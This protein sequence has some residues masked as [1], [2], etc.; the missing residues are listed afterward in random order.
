MES[1]EPSAKAPEIPPEEGFRG[2]LCV[3]GSSLA[4][5]STFG[6]LNAI[7]VFQ[8]TYQSTTLSD[9]T[10]S[11][12]S[13]IFA[14][15]LSLMWAPGPFYGRIIDTYG[16]APVLYP[17]ALLCVFSLCMTSLADRYYQIFLAQGL[18]FGL[19]AG[20]VF[21][22][23][24]VCAGQWFVRRRG[25]AL[26][27]A[28]AGSSLGGVV[29]P[30]FIDRVILKVGFYGAIRYTA[31]LV[32][33]PL[34]A[35]LFMIRARLPRK[36]WNSEVPWFD[37]SLFREKQFALYVFGA[38]MVMWGL[39]GPYDFITSMAE[40]AGFSPTLSLYLISLLSATSV[41]GRILPAYLGDTLG[42]FNV[43]STFAFL[44]G[45]SILTLWLPFDYHHS[46][47]GIIV[48][49]LVYGFV[50]GAF[51]SLMM[52]C[53]AKTGSIDTIGQRFGTFQM[54]IAV[55]CLTGLPIMGAILSRQGGNDYSGMQVFSSVC[56]LLGSVLLAASTYLLAHSRQN[57]KV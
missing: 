24:M 19:G 23:A 44:T 13:W 11:D 56:C 34:V 35:S 1:P 2:W 33:V 50:S 16:P 37:M 6:F 27:I 26:G 57:W 36:K 48:F 22:A 30:I 47:A 9:Y 41:L 5:F 10:P 7:G 31:L 42:H 40:T 51:I 8:S 54:V 15:Q 29:Y 20:G 17:C 38:Y 28:T 49:A 14:L 18:G 45:G 46:H 21:T 55:S 4:I 32:G 12:I 53:V 43:I 3:I 25:L 52:P 39:W